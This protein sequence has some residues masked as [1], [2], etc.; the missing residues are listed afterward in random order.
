MKVRDVFFALALD[1]RYQK[2][3]V[4]IDAATSEKPELLTRVLEEARHRVFNKMPLRLLMFKPD[5]S[6]IDLIDRNAIYSHISTAMQ[7]SFDEDKMKSYIAGLQRT[8]TGY[9][10]ESAE[11][12]ITA[13]FISHHTRY[14]ILSH[15][16]LHDTPGEVT[17]DAWKTG[18]IHRNSAGYRKLAKFC[19]VAAT[20]YGVSFGWMDTICIDKES[21]AE[22]DESIRSMYKWYHDAS[23]CVTYL[24]QTIAIQH[25]RDDSWFTRGWT[26]QELLAPHSIKFYNAKWEILVPSEQTD[27]SDKSIQQEIHKSTAISPDEISNFRSSPRNI[28]LPRKMRWAANRRVTREEDIAYSLMGI[29]DVSISIAYGEGSERAFFR[30]MKEILSTFKYDVLDI[31]NW[32]QPGPAP[33]FGLSDPRGRVSSLIPLSPQ[34]YL[35]GTERDIHWFPPSRPVTL[36]HLGLHLR[37]LLLPAISSD[38]ASNLPF[39]P[40]GKY[41]ATVTVDAGYSDSDHPWRQF[42]DAGYSDS[43]HPW[44]QF[45]TTY[46]LLDK[47]V[48]GSYGWDR[49]ETRFQMIFGVLNFT[50]TDDLIFLPP[51]THPCFAVCVSSS[52]DLA[53]P[54]DNPYQT[55][56]LTKIQTAQAVVFH[57]ER[58]SPGVLFK[59]PKTQLHEHGMRLVT[60]YL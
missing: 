7:A 30:L 1:I 16:W 41:Y 44:R 42:M 50:E 33:E 3:K 31:V 25:M 24:A 35:W 20:D 56:Q 22:L 36:T 45:P 29:F 49:T 2:T 5:G 53:R 28:R 52:Q 37:M 46:N 43:H 4:G 11:D 34:Q 54:R 51:S 10:R 14:A 13:R 48:S 27:T 8:S 55:V 6:E 38:P 18:A 17:H 26:L 19:E 60:T 12:E 15:T 59:I 40:I 39:T 21:S 32:A 23:I 57:L 47:D 9:T 58:T